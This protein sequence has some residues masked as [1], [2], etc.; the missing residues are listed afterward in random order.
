MNIRIGSVM[1][2][3][4]LIAT[5]TGCGT[6][7][8][9]LFGRGA[10]CGL[11]SSLGSCLPTPKLGNMMSAPCSTGVCPS[12]PAAAP[13]YAPVFQSQAP[14]PCE[15][16]S[17]GHNSYGPEVYSSGTCGCG[18]HGGE[19]YG[20]ETYMGESYSPT[21]SDPYLGSNQIIN[22]GVPN[23]GQPIGG[24]SYGQPMMQGAPIQ[25]DGFQARKFDA[26]G[27]KILWE[28]PLP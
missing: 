21:V 1:M 28:E 23:Y 4:T 2:A 16:E 18:Q 3:A 24:N 7:K 8:N 17:Y 13:A 20:G 11:C 19:V 25:S 27:N 12:A 9:F 10:R 22:S 5:S 6:M 15:C 14:A 26:D